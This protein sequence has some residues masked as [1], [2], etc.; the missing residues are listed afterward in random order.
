MAGALNAH[1]ALILPLIYL[2]EQFT[3]I[4][5]LICLFERLTLIILLI[6]SS[7]FLIMFLENAYLKSKQK[8]DYCYLC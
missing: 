5:L 2:S 6:Y 7:G 8:C 3:P 1:F 4:L